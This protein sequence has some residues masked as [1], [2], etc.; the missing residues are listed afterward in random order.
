[1]VIIGLSSDTKGLKIMHMICKQKQSTE[2][3]AAKYSRDLNTQQQ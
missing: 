3:L 1:M 2:S